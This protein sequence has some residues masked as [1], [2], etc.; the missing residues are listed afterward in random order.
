MFAFI[1]ERPAWTFC[2]FQV[3]QKEEEV[4]SGPRER[5]RVTI[6][7]VHVL[8]F[9]A[10]FFFFNLAL[11]SPTFIL[12]L[13][14]SLTLAAELHHMMHM[15]TP[16]LHHSVTYLLCSMRCVRVRKRNL[17][18][19]LDSQFEDKMNAHMHTS[20]ASIYMCV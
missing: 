10:I 17:E 7:R 5:S 19:T 3:P 20:V 16:P 1:S 18:C 12:L 13:T 15:L 4:I 11:S 2:V 6:L 14:L 8:C 9:Q